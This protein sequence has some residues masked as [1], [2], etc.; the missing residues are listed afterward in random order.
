VTYSLSFAVEHDYSAA[1]GIRVLVTKHLGCGFHSRARGICLKLI[2]RHGR[3][4]TLLK[5]TEL[6]FPR[7]SLAVCWRRSIKR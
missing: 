3:E 4:S 6:A 1:E 7:N 5:F 2:E